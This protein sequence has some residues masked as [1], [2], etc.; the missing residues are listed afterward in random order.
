VFNK[1]PMKVLYMTKSE[2]REVARIVQFCAA[3]L[4]ADYAARALS[5]LIR[6]ART[7]KSAAAL[8]AHAAAMGITQHPE[9][10]C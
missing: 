10:I 5:A 3:G 2:T 1:Q 4:G 9:F 6:A 8:R 7:N